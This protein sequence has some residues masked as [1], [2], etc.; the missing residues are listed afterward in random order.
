MKVDINEFLF[1]GKEA[2]IALTI[3][4]AVALAFAIEKINSAKERKKERQK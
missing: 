2:G 1:H 4:A 3:I